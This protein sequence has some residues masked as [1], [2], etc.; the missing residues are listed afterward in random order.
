MQMTGQLPF[1]PNLDEPRPVAPE[2][3]A[4]EGK[5]RWQEYEMMLTLHRQWV[6]YILCTQSGMIA[7]AKVR[8]TAAAGRHIAKQIFSQLYSA[9]RLGQYKAV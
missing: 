8:F 5:E 7:V 6:S 4:E 9:S 3:M 2:W 1:F